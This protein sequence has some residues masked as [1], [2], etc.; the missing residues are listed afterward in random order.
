MNRFR[1]ALAVA[2]AAT[3]SFAG[4]VVLA[5]TAA[6]AS[7]HTVV[8]GFGGACPPTNWKNPLVRPSRA[9]FN[10]ACEDGIRRIRWHSW[11]RWSA[12]GHGVHLQFTGTGFLHQP[13]TISLS[14]VRKHHGQRYFSHLVMRWTTRSGQHKAERLNWRK[15][16]PFWAWIQP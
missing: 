3:V 7:T 4:P 16:G 10:F 11:H 2:V 15:D 13:A 9:M 5:S 1:A 12:S 6:S 14:R 8:Y